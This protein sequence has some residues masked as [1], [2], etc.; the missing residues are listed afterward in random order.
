MSRAG[1]ATRASAAAWHAGRVFGYMVL[2]A[3]AAAGF[4]ALSWA[5]QGPPLL[6]PLWTM[7]NAAVFVFGTILVVQGR[8]PPILDRAGAWA[9]Q[10][11]RPAAAGGTPVRFA[12]APAMP[13][14]DSLPHRF[15]LGS[16]WAL[17]PCGM[18]YSAVVLAVLTADPWSGAAVMG[19]FAVCSGL[20]LGLAGEAV[21]RLQGRTDARWRALGQR[22]A[23]AA[24]CA[25]AAYAIVA[26][27]TGRVPGLA[28]LCL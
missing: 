27:L 25:M 14:Q 20:H 13:R 3:A 18:L 19:A 2:G 9:W 22:V 26:G 6:R 5:A 8:Q 24:I 17:L 16:A 1:G 10:R 15:A 7:L 28:D 12:G 4:G 23:G 11:L 21:R